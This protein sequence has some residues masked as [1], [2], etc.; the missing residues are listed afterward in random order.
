MARCESR[1]E[2]DGQAADTHEL[3]AGAA[4]DMGRRRGCANSG[5]PE[6]RKRFT[7]SDHFVGQC[8][9]AASLL[10]RPAP[11]TAGRRVKWTRISAERC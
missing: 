9:S 6:A 7:I 11:C 1:N 2:Y 10:A 4:F 3:H 5:T 8:E